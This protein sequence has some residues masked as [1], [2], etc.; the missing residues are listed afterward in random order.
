LL[1]LIATRSVD[2]PI[3]GLNDLVQKHAY[4]I[5][6]GLKAYRLLEQIKTQGK[7]PELMEAFNEVK[8]YLGYALLLKRYA[9]DFDNPTQEEIKIAAANSVPRVAPLFWSFR[10]MVGAGFLML[11]LFIACFYYNIKGNLQR[12]K[13]LLRWA[14][15]SLPLPWLA[16]ESGWFVAEY[17]RQPWAI[18]EILPTYMGVSSVTTSQVWMSMGGFIFF[19][20]LLFIAEMVLMLKYARLGPSSLGTQK[21]YFEKNKGVA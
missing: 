21:Y 17:G 2:T 10:I 3:M 14:L 16:I 1:G 15:W 18:A 11:A 19:Y 8:D 20:T 7:T 9:K 13:G 12:R 6:D 5:R 4:H